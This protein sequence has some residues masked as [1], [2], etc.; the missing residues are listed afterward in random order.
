M[1]VFNAMDRDQDGWI[2]YDDFKF[3]VGKNIQPT[4]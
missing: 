4:E 2:S 1:A 3:T